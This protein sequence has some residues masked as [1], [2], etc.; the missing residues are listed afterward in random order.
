MDP[1]AAG[2]I[3]GK[4]DSDE[5]LLWAGR[6][7]AAVIF[8]YPIVF[9]L[10]IALRLYLSPTRDPGFLLV[11]AAIL[12]L[13]FML[14][15]SLSQ[16]TFFGLTNQRAIVVESLFGRSRIY[17]ANWV[18]RLEEPILIRQGFSRVIFGSG[19]TLYKGVRIGATVARPPD[20]PNA[21]M[22]FMAVANPQ[23]VCE[24]ARTAQQQVLD[25][26]DARTGESHLN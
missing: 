8:L 5:V 3:Q 9:S 23:Q 1:E 2:A 12:V 4:L 25:A 15:W 14:C 16:R 19:G 22:V 18:N 6:P 11:M 17:S 10:L 7:Q 21:G 26:I 20:D 13:M 24:Q